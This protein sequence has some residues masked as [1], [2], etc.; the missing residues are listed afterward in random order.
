[1]EAIIIFRNGN[2]SVAVKQIR[3]GTQPPPKGKTV[4]PDSDFD[5]PDAD[6]N[7]PAK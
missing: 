7:T 2:A 4:A 5:R 1:V 3:D 6:G